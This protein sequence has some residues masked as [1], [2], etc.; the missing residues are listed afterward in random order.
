MRRNLYIFGWAL[1]IALPIIYGIQIY[2]TQDLPRVEPWQWLVLFGT[3]AL[4]FFTRDRD[5]VLKHHVV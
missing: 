4:I 5:D 3:V 2:I 1:L